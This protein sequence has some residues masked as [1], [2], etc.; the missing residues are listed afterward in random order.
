MVNINTIRD[1]E[2]K[3]WRWKVSKD[4]RI[5]SVE[6]RDETIWY[7]RQRIGSQQYNQIRRDE[8]NTAEKMIGIVGRLTGNQLRISSEQENLEVLSK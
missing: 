5:L 6:N 3:G 8:I 2:P 7:K 1:F 4:K